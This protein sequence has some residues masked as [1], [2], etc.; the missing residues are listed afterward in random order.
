[1][2]IRSHC[3]Q[4]FLVFDYQLLQACFTDIG[5]VTLEIWIGSAS[6]AD[7][8]CGSYLTVL[9]LFANVAGITV[10]LST[11]DGLRL[12]ILAQSL[13]WHG[14]PGTQKDYR[15]LFVFEVMTLFCRFFLN[16]LLASKFVSF[17]PR[18]PIEGILQSLAARP[19]LSAF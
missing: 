16:A 13:D 19:T 7:V 1:M 14:F 18:K 11:S 5:K 4:S 17:L 12:Q 9:A 2:A 3:F 6:Q 15:V 8:S 10:N